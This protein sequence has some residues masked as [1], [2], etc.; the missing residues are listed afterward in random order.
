MFRWKRVATAIVSAAVLSVMIP[1]AALAAEQAGAGP[2][3]AQAAAE[4]SLE[5]DDGLNDEAAPIQEETGTGDTVDQ[6][7]DESAYGSG[8]DETETGTE[9]A[10]GETDPEA[11]DAEDETVSDPA[12]VNGGATN[13]GAV[14]AENPADGADNGATAAAA[15]DEEAADPDGTDAPGTGSDDEEAILISIHGVVEREFVQYAEIDTEALA[16]QYYDRV[17]SNMDAGSERGTGTGQAGTADQAAGAALKGVDKVIYDSLREAVSEIAAGERATGTVRIPIPLSSLGLNSRLTAEDLGLDYVYDG[18]LNPE[19]ADALEKI[20]PVRYEEIMKCLIA[21]SGCEM[22]PLTGGAEKPAGGSLPFYISGNGNDWDVHLDG[23]V[24]ISLKPAD[25]FADP[26][27]GRYAIDTAR[28]QSLF[29]AA[30]TA[31]KSAGKNVRR[32]SRGTDRAGT[33]PSET[34]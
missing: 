9:A 10:A 7:E 25:G 16:A 5:S 15:G 34:K 24:E 31:S 14:P 19:L 20:A 27:S 3:E 13:S 22:Y 32:G 1:Q 6:H 21:D 33:C 28:I 18:T 8:T 11:E 23:Y 26:D 4:V 30:V 2:E 29:D 12:E 17:R